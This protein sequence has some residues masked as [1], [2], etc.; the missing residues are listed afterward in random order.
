MTDS[1]QPDSSQMTLAQRAAAAT[2]AQFQM[3]ETVLADIG[4]PNIPENR[5][6]ALQ[7]LSTNY[8]AEIHRAKK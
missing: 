5:L 2:R 4:V 8:A 1:T 6:I 7:I 3:I